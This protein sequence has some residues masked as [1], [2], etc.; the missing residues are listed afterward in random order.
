MTIRTDV[1]GSEKSHETHPSSQQPLLKVVLDDSERI[2]LSL[3]G[4]DGWTDGHTFGHFL[5]VL[6][7]LVFSGHVCHHL[8]DVN[9]QVKGRNFFAISTKIR[10]L[11][12]GT[13]METPSKTLNFISFS[14]F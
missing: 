9:Q 8:M 12:G 2:S 3:L 6:P 4:H 13:V 7:L 14:L 1:E 5:T 11:D 10:L